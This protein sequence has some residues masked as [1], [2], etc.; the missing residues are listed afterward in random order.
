M[1]ASPSNYWK[2]V[3][4]LDL[5]EAVIESQQ[6]A[7]SELRLELEEAEVRAIRAAAIYS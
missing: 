3:E 1:G 6:E 2:L 7:I 4:K 5:L